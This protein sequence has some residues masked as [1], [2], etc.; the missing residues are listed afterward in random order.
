MDNKKWEFVDKSTATVAED[1]R[2]SLTYWK[3]V[4]NRFKSNK[5]A[6]LGLILLAIIVAIVV[7]GPMTTDV[8]YSDQK[9]EYGNIPP[10]LDIVDLGDGDY[11]YVHKEY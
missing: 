2:P 5:I 7:I 10:V 8:S 4:W 3:D 9:L 6:I 1:T 11:V